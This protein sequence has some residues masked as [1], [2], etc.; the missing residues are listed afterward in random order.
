MLRQKIKSL[1]RIGIYVGLV[2]LPFVL[3]NQFYPNFF[4]Y[5]IFQI[6]NHAMFLR[7]LRWSFILSVALSWN[8]FVRRVGNRNG[9]DEEAILFWQSKRMTLVIWLVLF[10]LL[11]SENIL[12]NLIHLL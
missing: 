6:G 12:F 4:N 5:I 2:C 1:F 9:A 7:L 11:I 8:Y 3:M 10:E